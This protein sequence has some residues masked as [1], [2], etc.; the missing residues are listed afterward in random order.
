MQMESLK[1]YITIDSRKMEAHMRR[2]KPD[3][4]WEYQEIKL[5][6]DN[7]LIQ[8]IGLAIQLKEIYENVK[9]KSPPLEAC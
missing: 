5:P 1:E 4:T 8:T 2:K 6:D 3:G 9:F 7:L